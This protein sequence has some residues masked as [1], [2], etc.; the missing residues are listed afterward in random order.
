M[1]DAIVVMQ[2]IVSLVVAFQSPPS[3]R[4]RL[5]RGRPNC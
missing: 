5:I 4:R 3:C 1:M 2:A